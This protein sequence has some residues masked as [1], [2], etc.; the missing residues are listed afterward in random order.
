MMI[1]M[2]LITSFSD[3]MAAIVAA[4]VFIAL[5]IGLVML[6]DWTNKKINKK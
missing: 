4:I 5:W 2:I 3:V 6:Q 1:N